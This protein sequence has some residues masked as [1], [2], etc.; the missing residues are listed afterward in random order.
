MVVWSLPLPTGSEGPTLIPCA[1][2]PLS[3]GHYGLPSAPSWRTII[4]VTLE[5]DR[6]NSRLSHS[7]HRRLGTRLLAEAFRLEISLCIDGRGSHV[8]HCRLNQALATSRPDG[9]QA[10]CTLPLG[11]FPEQTHSPVSTP[12]RY[13]STH[14]QRFTC[15]RLPGSHLT[16]FSLPFPAT[17]TT[18]AFDQRSSRWFGTW[19]CNPAPRGPP[20]SAV[21]FRALEAHERLLPARSWRTV[22]SIPVSLDLVLPG[23]VGEDTADL[24]AELDCCRSTMSRRI[25]M[26]WKDS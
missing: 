12:S 5:P 2:R 22:F 8:P 4:C 3:V 26:P 21:Q 16:G 9:T 13:F 23:S 6:G 20:S 24:R 19:S 15:V 10:V 25:S 1:A 11:F 7:A 18:L 17:L 14:H